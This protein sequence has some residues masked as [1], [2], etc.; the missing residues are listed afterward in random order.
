MSQQADSARSQEMVFSRSLFGFDP[1]EVRAYVAKLHERLARFQAGSDH[2]TSGNGVA[3]DHDLAVAIDSTVSAVGGVLKAAREAARKIRDRAE[4]EAS[5]GSAMAVLKVRKILA[6]AEA[7]AFTLRKAAW[8]TSTELLEAAEAEGA[9]LRTAAERDALDIIGNAER[10]AH[11]KLAA[12]R[13]DSEN[14]MQM[15]NAECDRL[16]G[17]ARGKAKEMIRTAEDRAATIHEQ[18]PMLEKRHAE[19][20]QGIQ[21]LR[22]Q[23]DGPTED[24]EAYRTSTV[25]V[26]GPADPTGGESES[27]GGRRLPSSGV[28]YTE[29]GTVLTGARSVGWA[30]GTDSVRVVS[31]QTSRAS[32]EVDAVEVA[33]EVARLRQTSSDVTDGHDPGQG[34]RN[35][36]S[37]RGSVV[38][39][40]NTDPRSPALGQSPA[41]SEPGRGME[42]SADD[43]ADPLAALFSELRKREEPPAR[44]EKAGR[45]PVSSAIELYDRKLLPVVNRAVRA[46]KRQLTDVQR[47]QI[48][49]LE[50]DP[51]GWEI[52][53][54]GFAPYLVH[55]VSVM[56][57]EAYERG[58]SAASEISG[59]RLP[60][61]RGESSVGAGESFIDAVFGA[62][63][64][65]VR[66]GREAEQKSREI[67]RGVSGV[68][69]RWRTDEAERR[70]R[71]VAGRSYHQGLMAGFDYTDVEKFILVGG[72]GCQECALF[73][74]RTLTG[75][76][77]PPLPLHEECRCT[78]IPA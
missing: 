61:P 28:A 5:D 77:I 60:A 34:D 41:A 23:S 48:K 50:Q 53:L 19:L 44:E 11:R 25:R 71:F 8:D 66:S 56:Q 26:I 27:E 51:D 17:L 6:E 47:Q 76:D 57:R 45:D 30:D 39:T 46:V 40:P 62:V 73:A 21:T 10:K 29:D 65:S 74:G 32:V 43:S 24:S 16:M 4:M 55:S 1:L 59:T 67:S 15:A 78:V 72:E 3:G 64:S 22:E 38:Q 7:D 14:V 58:F 33:E 13:R 52:Q 54:S 9:R 42:V 37:D 31:S 63:E 36:G 18:V 69:R 68:Y 75:N 2:D 70:L 49:A 12:A 20:R 35:R